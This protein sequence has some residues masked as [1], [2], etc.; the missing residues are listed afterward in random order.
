MCKDIQGNREHAVK[1]YAIVDDESNCSL[2]RSEFVQLFGALCSPS[3]YL[4]KT[5]AGTSEMLG[6][7]AVGFQ[8][9]AMDEQN[10][11]IVLL[12]FRSPRP[13]K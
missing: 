11:W 9:E 10:S 1:M 12:P 2:A 8:I 4:M 3:P 6:R 5:C 7:K 13:C